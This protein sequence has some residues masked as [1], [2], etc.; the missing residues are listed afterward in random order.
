MTIIY[1]TL[2]WGAGIVFAVQVDEKLPYGIAAIGVASALILLRDR[3]QIAFILG[4][5]LFFLLGGLRLEEARP[6]NSPDHIVHLNSQGV[7]TVFGVVSEEPDERDTYTNLRVEV[8]EVQALGTL[9]DTHG[10]VLVRFPAQSEVKYGDRIQATGTLLAPAV[11]DTFDYRDKLA[12]QGIFSTMQP[13]NS[14]IIGHDEGNWFR[15]GL[16]DIKTRAQA[17]IED[18]L[19]EPQASLLSG[20]LLGDD[21]GLPFGVKDAFNA[22]GT[23]HVIAISGFN[24]TLI[25]V[26]VAGFLKA[27]FKSKTVV[28]VI[29]ILVMTIYTIFVG[30]S[31][32]VV[33]AAVMSAI[34]IIAEAMQRRTFVPASLAATAMVMSLLDPWILWDIGFQLSFAAVLGMA[35]LTPSLDRS[36]TAF[37]QYRLGERTGK[38]VAAWLSEPL[39][40]GFAAQ[41]FTLP[42]ILFYFGRLSLISPVV[43]LLIVP[44]QAFILFFGGAATLVSLALPSVGSILYQPTWLFLSWTTEIVRNFASL[45]IASTE[46][47]IAQWVFITFAGGALVLTILNATRPTWYD[48]WWQLTMQK[49]LYRR[50]LQLVPIIGLIV[51]SLLIPRLL[52]QPDDKLHITYLDMGQSNSALIQS[53]DGAV[54]LIN[55]GRFPSQLLTAL[56]D[57]LPPNYKQIDVLFVTS[58]ERDDIGG[59][60]EVVERYDIQAV[61]TS[62]QNSVEEDYLNLMGEIDR[63]DIPVIQATDGW[64]VQTGDGVTTEILAPNENEHIVIRLQYDEAV[65]L[66]TT[67]IAISEEEALRGNSGQV[68]ATVLQASD[69]AGDES[70]SEAWIET[71]NPQVVIVHNDPSSREIGAIGHVMAR[72]E[73][74]HVFRTDRHGPIEIITDGKTLEIQLEN[75]G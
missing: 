42:I 13:I 18:A 23:S 44:I 2:A 61:M 24:M 43:N 65:F 29:S 69:H 21:K 17:S 12:R 56:G 50:L 20:V 71:V 73:G 59:L 67:S 41:V 64:R 22:T 55:G 19:S 36:F 37:M 62:V 57:H 34:L 39:I 3:R 63:R 53:P 32:A 33:R 6:L 46:V 31:G 8:D 14:R 30:A 25:A 60:I 75:E 7:V 40:V 16:I 70:N 51:L 10:T 38:Q 15:E 47:S 58:D 72:F 74:R 9:H 45:S 27:M 1:L 66:F 26:M 35:L 52:R 28:V 5:V 4:I 49:P 54:F 11:L 68:Q 48:R